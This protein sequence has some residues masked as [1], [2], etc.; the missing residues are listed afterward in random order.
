ME[1]RFRDLLEACVDRDKSACR[2][3]GSSEW[4]SKSLLMEYGDEHS[5][6]KDVGDS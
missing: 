5:C 3:V 6:M 1:L 4:S 2:V